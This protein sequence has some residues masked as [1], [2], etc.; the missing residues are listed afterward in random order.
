MF[1]TVLVHPRL[2]ALLAEAKQLTPGE[3]LM[4]GNTIE[5]PTEIKGTTLTILMIGPISTLAKLF[6]SFEQIEKAPFA[7][8]CESY[9]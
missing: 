2:Q 6:A 5:G 3:D 4:W 7:Y 8:R 9:M 1:Q